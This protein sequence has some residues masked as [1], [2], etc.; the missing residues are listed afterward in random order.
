MSWY[1]S[2]S[3]TA[4]IMILASGIVALGAHELYKHQSK[5]QRGK[6]NSELAQKEEFL[7]K[8]LRGGDVRASMAPEKAEKKNRWTSR[9][10]AVE[11]TERNL[12]P[13]EGSKEHI[14]DGDRSALQRWI[15]GAAPNMPSMAEED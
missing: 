12:T 3:R 6:S 10:S 8:N 1:E 11:R 7:I 5:Q 4:T 13:G 14:Q 15:E 9:S 2:F